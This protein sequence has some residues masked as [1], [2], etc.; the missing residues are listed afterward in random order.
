MEQILNSDYEG[1][2]PPDHVTSGDT[3]WV[4]ISIITAF[5][6]TQYWACRRSA[7][8][9]AIMDD[10][11]C[12]AA[13]WKLGHTKSKM[14]KK[15]LPSYRSLGMYRLWCAVACHVLSSFVGRGHLYQ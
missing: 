7:C 4:D 12:G 9:Q 3:S 6:N 11:E 10:L 1:S 2:C 5:G 14:E 15:V 8:E 13:R